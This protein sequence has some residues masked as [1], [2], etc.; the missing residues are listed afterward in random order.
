M[1]P[2]QLSILF[3]MQLPPGSSHE[4]GTPATSTTPPLGAVEESPAEI[5]FPAALWDPIRSSSLVHP[6]GFGLI[7]L[8]FAPRW[9]RLTYKLL[10]LQGEIYYCPRRGS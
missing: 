4:A 8:F 9:A 3:Q 2:K 7:F 10:H 1:R 6:R 5:C